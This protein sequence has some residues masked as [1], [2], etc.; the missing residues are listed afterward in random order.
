MTNVDP[1]IPINIRTT[2]KSVPF[3][4]RPMQHV[5]MLAEPR[6]MLMTILGPY[7]SHKGPLTKRMKIV[8]PT[9]A[10]LEFQISCLERPRSSLISL[11]RGAA[12]NQMKKAMKK[13]HQEQWKARMWGRL[14][15]KSLIS[16]D[17]SSWSGSTLT[18]YSSYFFQS[19]I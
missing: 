8:D 17:L 9:P 15:D 3:R 14:K 2:N 16:V 6:M 10:I 13:H 11:R 5:G 19:L 12:E 4:T 1:L 7:L 18:K